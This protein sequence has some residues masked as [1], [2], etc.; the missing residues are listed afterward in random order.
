MDPIIRAAAVSDVPRQLRRVAAAV[1]VAPVAASPKQ[2]AKAPF[3]PTANL[4]AAREHASAAPVPTAPNDALLKERDAEIAKLRAEIAAAKAVTS[5]QYADAQRR[6]LET[7]EQKGFEHGERQAREQLAG[8]I[9][10]VQS[11]LAQVSQARRKLMEEAEDALV[12][13]AFAAVC[14]ILGEQ[15]VTKAGLQGAVRQAMDATRERERL[16]VRVH[17][18][19]AALIGPTES[20]MDVRFSADHNVELGGCMIDSASGSLDARFETQ[21]G[22]LAAALS[23]ARAARGAGLESI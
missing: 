14:R 9:E 19:D 4:L 16:V 20:G 22:L 11:V 18:D 7:G 8:Q 5:E 17:P 10:R 21:L 6:G 23:A 3:V 12:E 13:V 1:P 15:S 2:E